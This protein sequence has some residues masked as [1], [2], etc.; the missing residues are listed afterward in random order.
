MTARPRSAGCER[1]PRNTVLGQSESARPVRPRDIL[2]IVLT[3]HWMAVSWV[4]F[5][6]FSI[7]EALAI[8]GRAFQPW[9]QVA[10][11]MSPEIT[12]RTI[13]FLV[14]VAAAHIVRGLGVR[15]GWDRVR[16]PVAVGA[17]WGVLIVAMA[18]TFAPSQEPFI[19][20]QF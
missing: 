14:I 4:F 13:V 9:Q 12:T 1:T 5:R 19:Y 15:V 20:F 17:F 6:A 10:P 16:S 11:S 8:L 18:L 3:F 7:S 2:G